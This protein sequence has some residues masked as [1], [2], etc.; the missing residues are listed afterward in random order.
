MDVDARLAALEERVGALETERDEARAKAAQ[1][2]AQMDGALEQMPPMMRRLA[3]KA[4]AAFNGSS[5]GNA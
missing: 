2:Q 3:E 5:G 1:V 4:M